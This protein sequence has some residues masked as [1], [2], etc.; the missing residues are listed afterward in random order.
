MWKQAGKTDL[1]CDVLC[2]EP[3]TSGLGVFEEIVGNQV[4]DRLWGVLLQPLHTP[5]DV[6]F[7][8]FPA[9]CTGQFA[10]HIAK[11]LEL[12]DSVEDGVGNVGMR[13]FV[14]L[15]RRAQDFNWIE[16]VELHQVRVQGKTL[17]EVRVLRGQINKRNDAVVA[18]N[19]Q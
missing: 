6:E 10:E 11:G 19:D 5:T 12:L 18:I 14:A 2:I 1:G 4:S 7:V 8:C 16:E 3:L 13:Q 17:Q 9:R 15:H